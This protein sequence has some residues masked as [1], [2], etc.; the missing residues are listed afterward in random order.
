MKIINLVLFISFICSIFL[1]T[2]ESN[3]MAKEIFSIKKLNEEKISL[4]EENKNLKIEFANYN[5][6]ERILTFSEKEG[7][8]RIKKI[9]Y[10]RIPEAVLTRR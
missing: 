8:E 5:S 4:A 7:F 3:L 9:D 2:F 10:L 1:Y 6:F